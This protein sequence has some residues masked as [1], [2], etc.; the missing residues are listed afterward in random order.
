MKIQETFKNYK[1]HSQIDKLILI[2][3]PEQDCVMKN[4]IKTF[5]LRY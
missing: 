4:I 1:W 2:M 5:S 3:K